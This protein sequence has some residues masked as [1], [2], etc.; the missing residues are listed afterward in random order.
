MI[1]AVLALDREPLQWAELP[2]ALTTWVQSAGG[3]AAFGLAV[4]CIAYFASR[5]AKGRIG[6]LEMPDTLP[7]QRTGRSPTALLFALAT[8]AAAVLYIAFGVTGFLDT[9]IRGLILTAAGA[10]AIVAVLIPMFAGLIRL[11]P[12]RIWALARLSLKEAFRRRI[13]WGF[14]VL[15][16]VFLFA[17]WFVPFKP[18]DQLRK[19]VRVI[20]W[21]LTPLFLLVACVLGSFGIPTEV[22]DQS[23]HT[24]V[25]KPVERFEVVLG[26]FLGYAIL[27]TGGLACLT[28]ISLLYVVRGVRPEAQTESYKARM[29][30]YSDGLSFFGTKDP[31]AG[32]NV[33]RTWE[34]RTYIG[35]PHPSLPQQ[36]RQYAIWSF[37]K[38]PTY[39]DDPE[40][41]IL[42][43]FT[44]DIFR[45]TKGKEDR[46]VIAN[47]TFV[48]GSLSVPAVQRRLEEVQQDRRLREEQ[49]GKEADAK[50]KQGESEGKIQEWQAGKV[51]DLE[52]ALIDK[53]A[54][55]E[56]TDEVIDYHTQ[57][58]GGEANRR[59]G[60]QLA[61]LFTKLKET[62]NRAPTTA[63]APPAPALN[64]LVSVDRQSASA[65][66]KLGV[67]RRDLYVLAAE[68]PFWLN[69]IKGVIGMWFTIMLILG[70]AVACS[71]YFSGIISLLV[72][73][74]LLLAGLFKESFQELVTGKG[75]GPFEA[76]WRLVMKAPAATRIDESPTASLLRG[77]DEAYRFLV[78]LIL[79]IF[80]DIG[81]Y[82]LHPY[83][84]NGFDIS[85]SQVLFLDNFLPL[86]G[87]LLPCAVL[88]FYLMKFR[89]VANPT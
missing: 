7:A 20:Y 18:E 43:E 25:T 32:E 38:L 19:Y 9:G 57:S 31:H 84:A 30:I 52:S 15:A 58:L 39:F 83:V 60:M 11:R 10:C 1:F 70:I 89:E 74:F 41:P 36:Q 23:I 27:L 62:E 65:A 54:V 71:T 49:I 55:Y 8:A 86:V 81:R 63:D 78:R 47:F 77:G 29:P 6:G 73:L 53:Y 21:S 34:Y 35:G 61:R 46:G 3:V 56:A 33:G 76:A 42:F 48:D 51:R 22:K 40:T 75:G 12:R 59:V 64:V 2:A 67:A 26:R 85:V 88:A 66:Q 87:Y 69:F 28:A 14:S 50:R 37:S 68:R 5:A 45:L 82:D 17:D 80:P 13:V 16:L 4:F 79:N 44:F 72:T 24:I